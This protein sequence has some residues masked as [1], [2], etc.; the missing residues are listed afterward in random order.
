MSKCKLCLTNDLEDVGSH[1]FP[2]S[3]IRTAIYIDGKVQDGKAK[4]GDYEAIFEIGE[5]HANLEFFGASVLPE[6]REDIL[7]K[8]QTSE[9]IEKPKKNPL[10]DTKLVCRSCE[11]LFNPVETEFNSKIY[12]KIR[13]KK[14]PIKTENSVS[15]VPLKK[16]SYILCLLLTLINVWRASASKNNLWKINVDVEESIRDFLHKSLKKDISS[17]I[18]AAKLNLGIVNRLNFTLHFTEQTKGKSSEN[19]I[20]IDDSTNPYMIVTNQLITLFS[21]SNFDTLQ[22]PKI[23]SNVV[24]RDSIQTLIEAYPEELR[25][26]YLSNEERMQL[27]NNFYQRQASKIMKNALEMYVE[28]S[29]KMLGVFPDESKQEYLKD[30]IRGLADLKIGYTIENIAK[31]VSEVLMKDVEELKKNR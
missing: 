2:D 20:F 9:E 25:I 30:K 3:L 11:R 13:D 17:T 27:L 18:E 22:P 10:I 5:T 31:T 8:P 1:I 14:L 16:D 23:I 15:Y 24:S 12:S 6:K 21:E 26:Q 4:R 7:G 19:A 29:Q 28:T